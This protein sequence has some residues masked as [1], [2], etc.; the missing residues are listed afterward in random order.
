MTES[1]TRDGVNTDQ[2][3]TNYSSQPNASPRTVTITLPNGTKSIQYSHNS[4][5]SFLDGLVFQDQTLESG[6]NV[7]QSSSV[8]W[9]QGEYESPRP[10][11][12]EATNEL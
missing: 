2:A 12:V 7:L 1:W 6:N 4:P 5:G 11:R 10:T 8:Q 9:Q 3:V